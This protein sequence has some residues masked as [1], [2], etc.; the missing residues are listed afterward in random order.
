ML[1][2]KRRSSSTTSTR[3]HLAPQVGIPDHTP[4][5]DMTFSVFR[6]AIVLQ[7]DG[8]MHRMSLYVAGGSQLGFC[9]IEF[10]SNREKNTTGMRYNER[11]GLCNDSSATRFWGV[12]LQEVIVDRSTSPSR[13]RR[14]RYRDQYLE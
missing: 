14:G 6:D 2:D 12:G 11:R 3:T 1:S 4:D 8:I 13:A 5:P 7:A 9:F 10:S